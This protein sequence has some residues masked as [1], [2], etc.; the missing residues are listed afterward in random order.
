[1][2]SSYLKLTLTDNVK[3]IQTDKGSRQ[4]YQNIE[5]AAHENNLLTEK[6]SNFIKERDSFYIAS[7]SETGWPYVQHRGGKKGFLQVLSKTTIG[8][9]NY[10]GN[11]QYISQGN[12]VGND[13]VAMILMDY[14]QQRR[15][16]ILGKISVVSQQGWQSLKKAHIEDKAN[17]I[18]SYF[19]IDIHAFDWNCP[20]YI[21]P[22]FTLEEIYQ[23]IR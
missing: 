18:D 1:M 10:H 4:L 23:L 9:A 7:V 3:A 2:S 5:Q 20:K 13:K 16:K 14:T 11:K 19:V 22:R 15:L 12:F 17:N 21:R 8:F 6:E